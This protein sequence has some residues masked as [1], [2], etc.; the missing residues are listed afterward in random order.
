MSQARSDIA[1][2]RGSKVGRSLNFLPAHALFGEDG[3][4]GSGGIARA[5]GFVVE[6]LRMYGYDIPREGGMISYGSLRER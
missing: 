6:D 3:C 5:S 4:D 2:T 1:S